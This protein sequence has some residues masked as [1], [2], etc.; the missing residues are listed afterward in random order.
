MEYD[1]WPRLLVEGEK[2]TEEQANEIII[3]TTEF[4]YLMSNDRE[5][6]SQVFEILG[7]ETDNHNYP[8][9]RWINEAR[10]KVRS[11]RLN[12]LYNSRI[13]SS[14][15][16]GP[17]GWCNWDGSIKTYNYNIGKWPSQS[18]VLCELEEIAHAFP[19][20]QMRVQIVNGFDQE[21]IDP[22][23]ADEF[24]VWNGHVELVEKHTD[25]IGPNTPSDMPASTEELVVPL[26]FRAEFTHRERGVTPER[27]KVA[28]KQ[29]TS[30]V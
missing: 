6:K 4:G 10:Q 26:I 19:F 20:L 17:H 27:L 5:W 3:R 1:K 2:V 21:Y 15:L 18:E 9:M 29:V 11:L 14:N 12:Y 16:V 13:M 25:L 24:R 30:G 28:W 8:R 7:V 23:I 22:Q